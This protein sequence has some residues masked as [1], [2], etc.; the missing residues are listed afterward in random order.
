MSHKYKDFEPK[1]FTEVAPTDS[2]RSIFKWGD[3]S[4]NKVPKENLYKMMKKKF[5][6]TD[7]DFKKYKSEE[8]LGL[9]KVEFNCP[10]KLKEYQIDKIREIVGK[11]NVKTDDYTRLQVAYG[12]TMIDAYRLRRKIVENIPD[13]VVYPRSR[14]D[15]EKIVYYCNEEIIPIY[16]YGGGS[17]VTRGVEAVK[18]GITLDMRPHFNK[19]IKFNEKDQT[20]TVEAG[21][22]GPKLEEVLRNAQKEFGAKRAYTCGHFPQSFEYSSVGGWV[23]TRGAGQNS[24]YYGNIKDMVMAQAYATPVGVIE[25]LGYPAEAIG[26]SID[27]I[28]MGSEGTYGIL[29]H[30]TLKF[31]RWM[32]ENHIRFSYIF[33]NWQDAQNAAREIMQSEFGFPSV[34]RL[35]D[36]EETDVMLKLYG[37]EETVLDKAMSFKGYKPMER[38]LFL[39]F[40]D[41]EIGFC[42]NIAKNLKKICKKYGAMYLTGLP[43]K[44][45][46]KGR[47]TDPYLRD[48]MQDFG[49]MTDTLECSVTWDQMDRVHREVREYCKSRPHTICMTHMSHVYPQGANLYFIFI[50]KM[51]MEEYIEYQQGILDNIQK[52]GA[53]MSHHHGIGKMTAPWLEAQ[54]GKNSMDVFRAL[55]K[56]FDPNNILNPG[57]TIGLDLEESEKRDFVNIRK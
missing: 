41:G 48:N 26:P 1:W 6:L 28:M 49:V 16:V 12:K 51:D 50:A 39:G 45:W 31:F 10:I 4:E 14:E 35:S 25:T 15:I 21:M 55:K 2:Y 47:F 20:I 56:H 43:T 42:K 30:V 18:G 46:E 57:G 52:A 38:C 34:F 32:P 53:A 27:E 37:V 8:E 17:S 22:S 3:P 23:V 5:N 11:E 9:E 40:T 36:P 24:T 44:G 54:I 33:K 7:E 19:V 29:T 13:I